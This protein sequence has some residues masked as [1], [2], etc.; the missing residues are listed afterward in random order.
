[1]TFPVS[2]IHAE[3]W[4]LTRCSVFI[5]E[6]SALCLEVLPHLKL[7]HYSDFQ[8]CSK[9]CDLLCDKNT[10]LSFPPLTVSSQLFFFSFF[11]P[12][13]LSIPLSLHPSLCFS[14]KT[15]SFI[16]ILEVLLHPFK[17]NET[18]LHLD[19]LLSCSVLYSQPLLFSVSFPFLFP[20]SFSCSRL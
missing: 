8:C 1:M 13:S 4:Q 6:V 20:S 14:V 7:F 2:S 17:I 11:I 12:I 9:C 19:L 16:C 18:T 5:S 3:A 10:P 15:D